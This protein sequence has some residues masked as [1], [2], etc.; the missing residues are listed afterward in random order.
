MAVCDGSY[1][2]KLYKHGI[3]AAMKIESTDDNNNI[4][5]TVATSG[6]TADPYRAELLGI[7]MTLLAIRFL[8]QH[9]VR[10]TTGLIKIGCDNE[11]AGWM[12]GGNSQS[13]AVQTQHFDLVKAMR[14]IRSVLRTKT[15]F[16]H[17]MVT[18]IGPNHFTLSQEMLS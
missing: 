2:P 11:L 14:R 18:R 17:I 5:G 15:S 12:S 3:A 7:Y 1:K 13:V 8:E 9:N 6:I 10:F 4:T 16:Y